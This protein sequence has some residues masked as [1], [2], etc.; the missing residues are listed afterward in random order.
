MEWGF[1]VYLQQRRKQGDWHFK[2]ASHQEEDP[3]SAETGPVWVTVSTFKAN[4]KYGA[5]QAY[6][7]QDQRAGNKI[8]LIYNHFCSGQDLYLQI[9]SSV[10]ISTVTNR[11]KNCQKQLIISGIG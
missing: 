6:E 11:Q 1:G 7:T 3:T 2:A 4:F 8:T 9:L 10:L 5:T